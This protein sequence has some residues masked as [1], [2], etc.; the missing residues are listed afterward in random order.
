MKYPFG[1]THSGRTG[2]TLLE[3][4][5]ALA[6]IGITLV[7]V[8]HTVN[9]H[10]NVLYENTLTTEMYQAAKEKMYELEMNPVKSKG[11]IDETGLQYESTVT[12]VEEMGLIELKTVIYGKGKEV[13]LSEMVFR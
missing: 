5:I 12:T 1:H 11:K 3:I 10:A 9:F 8:I 13:V 7:V 2:F 6:I 4:M